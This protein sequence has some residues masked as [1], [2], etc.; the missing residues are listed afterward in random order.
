M[1]RIIVSGYFNPLHDG[2]LDMIENARAMGDYVIVVVN[3]DVQQMLKKGKIILDEN[4]R[5]R[6]IKALRVVDEAMLSVDTDPSVCQTLQ[7]I[8]QKYPDDELVFG[9]G[10]DRDS[11]RAIPETAVCQECNI[12]LVFGIAKLVDSSSRINEALGR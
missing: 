2:H 4:T 10:G 6:I 8:R 3:N 12:E 11:E 5:I 9:N 7:L 1:K